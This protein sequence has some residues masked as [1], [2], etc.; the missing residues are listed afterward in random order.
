VQLLELSDFHGAIEA[1]SSNI[2]AATLAASFTADRSANPAT[3]TLAAGDNIGAA[4]PISAFFNEISTIKALNLMRLDASTFGNHEHDKDLNHV[5]SVIAAS[6]FQWVVSNY[7]T[8]A[9]LKSG[10]KFVKPFT[11]INRG[12]VK[13]GIV[14][15]NTVETPIVTKPGNLTFTDASGTSQ[16]IKIADAV[17]GLNQ[18]IAAAKSA[19]ADIVVALVH[20]G[21]VQNDGSTPTGPLTYIANNVKGAAVIFGGHTHLAYSNIIPNKS[22]KPAGTLIGQVVNAGTS[23]NRVQVCFDFGSKKIVGSTLEVVKKADV[24]KLTPDVATAALVADYKSKLGAQVDGKIG[25]VSALFPNNTWNGSTAKIQR[26]GETALGDY[27]ADAMRI[28][29][30]TD[31]AIT[32]GGGIRDSLPASGYAAG[33][34]AYKRAKIFTAPDT[35]NPGPYDIT[36]GDALAVLPFG[37]FA[38][39]TKIT[40]KGLWAA[41]ANGI[42]GYPTEG[43]FP[44]ISG[45]KF[46][47]DLS[48][49]LGNQV[50]A[51]T[52]ADGTT[53]AADDTVY[54]VTTNDYMLYGGDG[55]TMFTPS[56]GQIRD[57]LVDVLA[58]T[59]K[60]DNSAGK[61]TNVPAL[62]GR[63]TKVG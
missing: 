25:Q 2:G 43:R 14:G 31:F 36:Y 44:Q 11:I 32:N 28:R 60:A 41:V 6:D 61:S 9:P 5:Q 16:T 8:L 54:S 20:D 7:S 50:T 45:F 53:I 42:S 33:N 22:Y 24:S 19:G 55:Y 57:L 40:G 27:I 12:G 59:F 37:N 15:S 34:P 35:A 62:D 1:T 30:G 3:F 38:V 48:K 23:Y 46:T 58:D 4:P 17:A 56:K 49:P 39:T 13:V 47:F 21:F 51:I 10:D 63:I 26:M 29:Y 18:Q 52:K